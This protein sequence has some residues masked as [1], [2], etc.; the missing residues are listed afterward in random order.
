MAGKGERPEEIRIKGREVKQEQRGSGGEG[1]EEE[2]KGRRCSSGSS[3]TRPALK[4]LTNGYIVVTPRKVRDANRVN[5]LERAGN[6]KTC[7][8]KLSVVTLKKK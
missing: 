1:R 5:T 6:V 8:N 7:T 4:T 2:R 3:L